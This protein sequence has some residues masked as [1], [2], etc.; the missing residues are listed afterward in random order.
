M[1]ELVVTQAALAHIRALIAREEIVR[2]MVCVS[3]HSG[4][5]DLHRGANGEALWTREEA[6]WIAGVL[7]AHELE[8]AGVEAPTPNMH[9]ENLPFALVGRAEMPLLEGC[10]LTV[11]QGELVVL[12]NAI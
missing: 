11:E 7:D 3:W 12:E 5:A 9:V 10:T 4:Q 1:A 2:P 6:R 8:E